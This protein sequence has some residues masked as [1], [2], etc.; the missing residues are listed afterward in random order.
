M[1]VVQNSKGYYILYNSEIYDR[2][3]KLK[4]MG[5]DDILI[6]LIKALE[7]GGV[8]VLSET[9]INFYNKGW[10]PKHFREIIILLIW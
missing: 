2:Y 10:C 4:I 7:A 8:K 3:K 5:S 1:E 6:E 9:A